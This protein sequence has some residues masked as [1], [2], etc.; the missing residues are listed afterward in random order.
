MDWLVSLCNQARVFTVLLVFFFIIII[1]FR[2]YMANIQNMDQM[3]IRDIEIN[4]FLI[5][6][7]KDVACLY[8]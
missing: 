7:L 5:S 1:S 2:N 6:Q 3:L 8:S 4:V